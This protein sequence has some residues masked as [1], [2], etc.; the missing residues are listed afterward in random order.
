[1]SDQFSRTALRTV[2]DPGAMEA[3]FR[4]DVSLALRTLLDEVE[5]ERVD[6]RLWRVMATGLHQHWSD[7]RAHVLVTLDVAAEVI[8]IQ[9]RELP[10]IQPGSAEAAYEMEAKGAVRNAPPVSTD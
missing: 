8:S 3:M 6:C 9:R 4:K 10:T 1:M 2:F 5:A 7:T